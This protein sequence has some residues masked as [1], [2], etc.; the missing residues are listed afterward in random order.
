VIIAIVFVTVL[1]ERLVCR[2]KPTN[3]NFPAVQSRN[4]RYDASPGAPPSAVP[5]SRRSNVLILPGRHAR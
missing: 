2:P 3:R 4:N 5:P 1:R